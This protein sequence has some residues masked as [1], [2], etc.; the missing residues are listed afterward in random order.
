MVTILLLSLPVGWWSVGYLLNCDPEVRGFSEQPISFAFEDMPVTKVLATYFPGDSI[1]MKAPEDKEIT[2]KADDMEA[3]IFMAFVAKLTD[4][5]FVREHGVITVR[6]KAWVK[7][8]YQG[9]SLWCQERWGFTP[10]G[11]K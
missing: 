11:S 9:V 4:Y 6:E 5:D 7:H 1:R 8:H 3:Y 2:L 10:W